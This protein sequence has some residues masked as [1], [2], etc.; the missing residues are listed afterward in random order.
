M[1]IQ[2]ETDG[3]TERQKDERQ[4]EDRWTEERT[5]RQDRRI[6]LP[7]RRLKMSFTFAKM[8]YLVTKALA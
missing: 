8:Q 2:T 1:D 6:R 5:D 3:R 4:T 7:C